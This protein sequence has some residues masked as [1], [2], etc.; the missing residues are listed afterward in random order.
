MRH[1][2]SAA[3]LFVVLA[4]IACAPAPEEAAVEEPETIEA[5]TGSIEAGPFRLPYVIEG[6]GHP[7][8]IIGTTAYYRRAFSQN[9]REHLRLV[10]M[11]HRG[12]VPSPGPVD[13]SEYELEKLIDD[14]ERLRQHLG[15][16]R[17]AV[18]GHSGNSYMALEYGKKY[19]E[20]TSHV[21]MIGIAPDLSEASGELANAEYE[22]LADAD[23]LA[24][25]RE[26]MQA[27]PD[28]ELEMLPPEEA[29][30]QSY[31]RNAARV[32]YDPRFDCTPLWEDVTINLEMIEHVWGKLFAEIDITEG[33]EDFDRPVFLAL[34]RYDFIVAPPS[35][36]DPIAPA[37]QNLTIR[38]FEESGHTPQFEEPE[39][40]DQ[41]LLAWMEEHGT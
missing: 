22:K 32:W 35:S 27:L 5:D 16:E 15:L 4:F 7:A 19:P 18:I 20:H 12:F 11:D 33:L 39:L 14:I 26:N 29:F 25:E 21:V 3:L 24:A 37:F 31:I 30:I 17:V 38:V 6:E 23:R 9:L 34:G 41:E 10:F 13:T 1:L 2:S 36:W 40:F 28:E 8:I